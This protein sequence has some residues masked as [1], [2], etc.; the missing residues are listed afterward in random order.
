MMIATMIEECEIC[1]M[2]AGQHDAECPVVA[3]EPP[4][5]FTEHSKLPSEWIEFDVI[6]PFATIYVDLPLG[7]D[8][9]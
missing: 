8:D 4:R 6:D 2:T 9:E 5:P 1:G 7:S 3:V